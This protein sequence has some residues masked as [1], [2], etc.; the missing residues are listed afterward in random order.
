MNLSICETVYLCFRVNQPPQNLDE[1]GASLALWDKLNGELTTVENKFA[2]LNEQ[3]LILEKYEVAI[4]E[5]V[6]RYLE[7]CCCKIHSILLKP[8]VFL[9]I[10]N[11]P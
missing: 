5:E 7:I 2:P 9:S 11:S 4:P 10:K 3:F 1:L 8:Y 6:C